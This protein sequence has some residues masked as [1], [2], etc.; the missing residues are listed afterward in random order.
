M[1]LENL[2]QTPKHLGAK[3]F[4]PHK[5]GEGGRKTQSRYNYTK[6]QKKLLIPPW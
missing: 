2:S 5:E 4:L 6:L 3:I 1:D